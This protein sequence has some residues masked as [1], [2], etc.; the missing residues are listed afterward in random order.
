MENDFVDP[1]V[2]RCRWSTVKWSVRCEIECQIAQ[3]PLGQLPRGLQVS[4]LRGQDLNLRPSGYE[5]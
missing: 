5:L 1:S 2:R 3:S 4:K